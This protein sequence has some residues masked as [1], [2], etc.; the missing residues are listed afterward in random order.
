MSKE[1][2]ELL[3]CPF[4]KG[5]MIANADLRDGYAD[6]P[7]D[8]DAFAYYYRCRSCAAT[9]GWSKT[10]SGAIRYLNMRTPDLREKLRIAEEALR[11]SRSRLFQIYNGDWIHDEER[12]TTIAA[13]AGGAVDEI[14]KALAAIA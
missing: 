10:K 4:C 5:E 8:P 13:F 3:D 1:K 7:N 2:I 9:S 12:F 14:D 11:H 6:C